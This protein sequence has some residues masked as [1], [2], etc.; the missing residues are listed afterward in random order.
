M[1]SMQDF[2]ASKYETFSLYFSEWGFLSRNLPTQSVVGVNGVVLLSLLLTLNIFHR[3][4][5]L[6]NMVDGIVEVINKSEF[7]EVWLS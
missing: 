7:L 1:I 4:S 6:V 3:S 2:S 5:H